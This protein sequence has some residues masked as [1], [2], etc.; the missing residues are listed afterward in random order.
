MATHRDLTAPY[1]PS[2]IP[3][4]IEILV[5]KAAVDP[6]FKEILFEKRAEAAEAIALKL[7]PAEAAMLNAVPAA[8]LE[9]IIAHTTVS[10]K[11]R[12][13]FLGY[14]AAVMLAALGAVTASC[15]ATFGNQPDPPE[16]P[17]EGPPGIFDPSDNATKQRETGDEPVT[18]GIKPDRP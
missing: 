8:Q 14:A 4:G 12:P 3:R 15:A 9:T 1:S 6:A 5:K 2:G 18:R 13:A 17:P 16:D 7:E 11:L 10:P